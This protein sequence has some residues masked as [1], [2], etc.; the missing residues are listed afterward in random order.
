MDFWLN[1]EQKILRQNVRDF[2]EKEIAPLALELDEN[3]E[4]SYD[5]TKQMAAL[6]LF[7]IY[8][9]NEYG[10]AGMDYL[11]YVVAVEEICRVDGSHGAT[12]A[13]GN[14]LGFGPIYY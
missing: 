1:D 14:S 2:A 7:G 13:A 8:V 6:G 11:S 4:F 3:E 10:G 5:L 9:P 12:V